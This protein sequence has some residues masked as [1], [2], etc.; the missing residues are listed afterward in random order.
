MG[1][2]ALSATSYQ[3]GSKRVL[4]KS[5]TSAAN[6]GSVILA[7]SKIAAIVIESIVVYSR[8][9]IT[10]D[11]TTCAVYGGTSNVITFIDTNLAIRANLNALNKQVAWTGAVRLNVGE[12]VTMDLI[13][14]GATAVD[15]V[16]TITYRVAGSGGYLS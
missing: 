10:T 14:V 3:V 6:A 9:T 7:T 16:V 12:T 13:G 15:M 1:G 4:E 2:I 8:S 5:V 11:L